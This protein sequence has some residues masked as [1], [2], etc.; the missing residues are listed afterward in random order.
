M[1]FFQSRG[2]FL[3]QILLHEALCVLSLFIAPGHWTTAN[4]NS[5]RLTVKALPIRGEASRVRFTKTYLLGNNNDFRKV[6]NINSISFS[7]HLN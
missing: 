5:L 6:L 1:T 7:P 4:S 2:E 3:A